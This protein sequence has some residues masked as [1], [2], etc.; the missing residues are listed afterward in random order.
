MMATPPCRASKVVLL[1]GMG[2]PH[3][4][5]HP[6]RDSSTPSILCD[7]VVARTSCSAITSTSISPSAERCAP[8]DVTLRVPTL[9]PL[10]PPDMPSPVVSHTSSC[11]FLDLV[12]SLP[13]RFS[14]CPAVSHLLVLSSCPVALHSFICSS[15]SVAPHFSVSV[16][17]TPL[18]LST[19]LHPPPSPV[20]PT[21]SRPSSSH[22]THSI[23]TLGPGCSHIVSPPRFAP[24]PVVR[25]ALSRFV[26]SP[27][28]PVT[29]PCIPR[30]SIVPVSTAAAS[31]RTVPHLALSP[32]T[33]SHPAVPHRSVLCLAPSLSTPSH[34]AISLRSAP[35]S[36]PPPLSSPHSSI[37]SHTPAP[38][39][40]ASHPLESHISAS[41]PA[42]TF[43]S[44][45]HSAAPRR[46]VSHPMLSYPLASHT[47]SPSSVQ[48][49]FMVTH[50]SVL[51]RPSTLSPTSSHST[52]SHSYSMT[53][54]FFSTSI[55][56]PL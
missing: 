29:L 45:T 53:L 36:P 18:V 51:S 41:H 12:E 34:P 33:S 38:R 54:S 24:S 15:H 42:S 30:T 11:P 21:M 2:A 6:R 25:T 7:V 28:H 13:A 10:A 16:R 52:S 26:S 31:R 35:R 20:A 46:P 3:T 55:I 40:T 1:W 56:R 50:L 32:S 39:R 17:T 49:P 8:S 4:T 37:P 23:R 48:T 19:C 47:S 22:L 44:S 9:K 5:D 27:S 14:P 43:P